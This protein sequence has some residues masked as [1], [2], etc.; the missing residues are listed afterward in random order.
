MNVS[1]L[2]ECTLRQLSIFIVLEVILDS[3]IFASENKIDDKQ[4]KG[5]SA[6]YGR[7]ACG[8]ACAGD[9]WPDAVGSSGAPSL[10]DWR[11]VRTGSLSGAATGWWCVLCVP[12]LYT[13][14]QL[15]AVILWKLERILSLPPILVGSASCLERAACSLSESC[16]SP[17]YSVFSCNK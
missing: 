8:G 16:G 14:F 17:C 11:A 6:L 2:T 12:A 5:F 13:V 7:S 4:C 15:S 10:P 1:A 3:D 9:C